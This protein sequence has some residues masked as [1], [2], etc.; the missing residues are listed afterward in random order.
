[1]RLLLSLLKFLFLLLLLLAV[2]AL[3]LPSSTHIERSRVIKQGPEIPFNLVNRLPEWEKWSPWHRMDPQMKITYSGPAEGKGASYSWTSKHDKVGNGKQTVADSKPYEFVLMDMEFMEGGPARCGFYFQKT[4]AGTEVKWTLD[5]EAGWNLPA[6]YFG[7]LADYFVGP[8]FE[9]G[10]SNLAS[11]SKRVYERG[12]TMR[13]EPGSFPGMKILAM[14][15]SCREP[16]IGK[17]LGLLYGSLMETMGKAGLQMA[18]PPMAMYDEPSGDIFRFAAGLPVDKK[19]EAAIPAG[20]EYMEIPA[21]N[22]LIC[23]FNGLY[24]KTSEAYAQF[25]AE[26]KALGLRP[27][28]APWESYVTDPQTV[29]DPMAVRTEIYWPVEPDT[30]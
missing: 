12:Y 28:G 16:E 4:E 8:H 17:S 30:K 3:F 18:G 27:S 15:Y 19:P 20:T 23:H 9:D 26:M 10:L 2:I 5:S 14:R 7:L 25:P 13:F 1:M 29:K 21:G 22:S 6:R 11:E 24:Q